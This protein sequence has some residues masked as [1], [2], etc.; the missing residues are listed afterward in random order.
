MAASG[1]AAPS[2]QAGTADM[3]ARQKRMCQDAY[4]HQVGELAYLEAKL[5]LTATQ[6]TLFDRWK[7]TKLDIARRGEADCA[8]RQIDSTR[9]T[10]PDQLAREAETLKR[11]LGE[12]E[13]ERP[14]LNALYASLSAD[15]RDTLE[16]PGDMPI[17]PRHIFAQ[18]GPGGDLMRGP[19]D[20]RAPAPPGTPPSAAP[21]R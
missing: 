16:H 20:R 10:A 1:G 6:Q 5:A 2:R 21:P 12:I 13:A 9:A 18:M 7:N 8:T 14:V 15:Q 3:S 17:M 19:A 11:R 4:A